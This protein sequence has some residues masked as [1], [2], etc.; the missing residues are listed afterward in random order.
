MTGRLRFEI[1]SRSKSSRARAGRVTTPHGSFDT[2]A[3][4]PV[5]TRGSVKGLLPELVRR[6]GAQ[7]V[8]ANTYPLLLRPGAEVVG[9]LGGLHPF[10][11]WP[12]PILTDSGGYQAYSMADINAVDDEGV[13]FRSIVDGSEVRLTPEGAIAALNHLGANIIMAFDDCPP[14]AAAAPMD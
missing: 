3:F 12:G 1:T 4:M 6:T 13:T 5:G 10:T 11:G 2:P 9:R 8:L 7:I 14:S